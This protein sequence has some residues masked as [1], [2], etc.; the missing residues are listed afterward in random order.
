MSHPEFGVEVV[1]LRAQKARFAMA[2]LAVVAGC[3]MLGAATAGAATLQVSTA[4]ADTGDCQ[5]SAC[6]TV[7][8]A[9]SQA[10]EDD[11]IS[12][13][14]GTYTGGFTLNKSLTIQGAGESTILR[15][16]SGNLAVFAAG[17]SGSTLSVCP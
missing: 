15:A 14:A 16:T 6:L 12:V 8:Y 5:S 2:V 17:S 13:A 1:T 10:A 9:V 3:L 11:T 7:Q 4:G